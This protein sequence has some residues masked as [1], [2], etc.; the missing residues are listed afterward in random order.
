MALGLGS[1]AEIF[2]I[3]ILKF[4]A[5]GFSNLAKFMH[6]SIL[7]AWWMRSPTI[8]SL[9]GGNTSMCIF[10]HLQIQLKI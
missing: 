5:Q 3:A 9:K 1:E 6:P 2:S 4:G 8:N 7:T 10:I